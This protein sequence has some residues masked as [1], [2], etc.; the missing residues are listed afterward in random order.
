[1]AEELNADQLV[2]NYVLGPHGIEGAE[3]ERVLQKG[4]ELAGV[5]TEKESQA[6]RIEALSGMNLDT[7]KEDLKEAALFREF[8]SL[9]NLEGLS[10]VPVDFD[11]MPEFKLKDLKSVE[12]S[13]FTKLDKDKL[14][15]ALGILG[16]EEADLL[17]LKEAVAKMYANQVEK[18]VKKEFGDKYKRYKEFLTANSGQ[19]LKISVTFGAGSRVNVAF[20]DKDFGEAYKSYVEA[21][22]KEKTDAERAEEKKTADEAA[23]KEASDAQKAEELAKT[24][25][26]KVLGFLGYGSE[27]KP[28]ETMTGF[29]RII[30]GTDP[31]G[32][33]ILGLFGYKQFVG[34]SFNE[35]VGMLPSKAQASVKA[36][37]AKV[38]N[39][40]FYYKP[41]AAKASAEAAKYESF[42]LNKFKKLQKG[43][44]KMPEK[45]VVLGEEVDLDKSGIGKITV[46]LKNAGE[47]MIP[48]GVE[49][50]L[51]G[52]AFKNDK[53]DVPLTP[54]VH[55]FEHKIPSSVVFKGK[56]AFVAS[57]ATDPAKQ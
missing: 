5:G 40:S 51:D 24:P 43:E 13:V 9:S 33:F 47:V 20:D 11:L 39:T 34:E 12:D 46:D 27:P 41:E 35:L 8:L 57:E 55:T 23:A 22:P 28:P 10:A 6:K 45:G 56:V 42:D 2:K 52:A 7:L 4:K 15:G 48:K 17:A 32:A 36:L 14:K 50:Y 19:N 26:G 49:V 16:L 54:G 25:I 1:M 29:Q 18:T 3:G 38:L 30:A 31:V 44:I 37:E 53:A 21:N